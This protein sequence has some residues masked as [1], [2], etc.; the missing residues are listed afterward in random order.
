MPQRTDRMP[1][2]KFKGVLLTDIPTDYLEWLAS[3]SHLRD[4]LR[5]AV[6]RELDARQEDRA[7]GQNEMCPSPRV[8]EEI[9]GAGVRSLARRYHPDAGGSHEDMVRVNDAAEWLRRQVRSVA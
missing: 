4:P 7:T 9:I 3:L 5:G 8:A 2:G 1:F 6:E